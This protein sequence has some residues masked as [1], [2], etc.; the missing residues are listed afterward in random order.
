M[1][2]NP[3][4][5]NLVESIPLPGPLSLDVEISSRCNFSCA[6][7]PTALPAEWKRLGFEKLDMEDEL[8]IKIVDDFREM[9]K[10]RV[11]NLHMMGESQLHPRFYE[12]A[13][14][15]TSS[16]IADSYEMRTNGSLLT[17]GRAQKLVDAGLNRIGISVEAV[18]NEGYIKLTKRNE[19]DMLDQVIAG[20]TDLYAASR[21]R[22]HIFAKIIDFQSPE[23]NPERFM[24]LFSSITDEVSTEFP[25]Q[26][27][28][29]VNTDTTLG[30]GV[31]LSVNGDPLQHHVVC[32]YPF[33]TMAISATGKVIMCCFNWSYQSPRANVKE[34]TVKEIWNGASVRD[35]QIAHLRGNRGEFPECRNCMNL[36]TCPDSL[37][38]ARE[39]LI[40]RLENGP[41]SSEPLR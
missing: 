6:F 31:H 17:Q 21:G 27:N 16:G 26:W 1:K 8:F 34:N 7:C 33:Y 10:L 38:S 20:V 39:E 3:K 30:Q 40:A 36:Q 14:Y 35:Y 37:D 5:V 11:F 24:E 2:V 32:P 25:E 13:R 4:R 9:P 41:I 12:L 18:T 15:A 28:G 22:C 29:G 23:T 19:I